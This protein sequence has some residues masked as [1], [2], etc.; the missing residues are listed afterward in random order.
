MS[1]KSGLNTF[2]VS[3]ADKALID[4]EVIL[5]ALILLLLFSSTCK[6]LKSALATFINTQ[7]KANVEKN[8]FLISLKIVLIFVI[9]SS[10]IF[11]NL[12]IYYQNVYHHPNCVIH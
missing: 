7:I 5:K 3:A 11:Q 6:I 2:F 8:K 1:H 10:L 9:N 4:S 12:L